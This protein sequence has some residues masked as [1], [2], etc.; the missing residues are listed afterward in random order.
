[1]TIPGT[2]ERYFVQRLFISYGIGN[3]VKNWV[4]ANE[5]QGMTKDEALKVA[6]DDV[7]NR[8]IHEITT[9]AIVLKIPKYGPGNPHPCHQ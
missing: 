9:R 8:V 7:G 5:T 2:T 4:V 3:P 6:G 1:M